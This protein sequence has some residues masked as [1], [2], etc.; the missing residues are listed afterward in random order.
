[1]MKAAA[2]ALV[3]GGVVMLFLGLNAMNSP[4]SDV[5]Q[6]FTGAPSDRATWLLVGGVVMLAAGLGGVL[7]G[8]RRS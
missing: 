4:G 7:S 6:F 8:A 2:F 1:M 3:A 5:L